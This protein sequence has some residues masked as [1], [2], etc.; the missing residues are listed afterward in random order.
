MK[1][2]ITILFIIVAFAFS[3]VYAQSDSSKAPTDDK[4]KRKTEGQIIPS[5]EK[6]EKKKDK[7]IDKDG[8]GICDNRA[9]GLTFQK[10]RKRKQRGK[11][12]EGHGG[13]K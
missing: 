10:M 6:P 5:L 1:H 3:S 8:D 2:L 12:G 13:K 4:P 7:F 9:E 11:E